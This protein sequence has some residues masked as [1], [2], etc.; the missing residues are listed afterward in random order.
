MYKV[1]YNQKQ[2]KTVH[3]YIKFKDLIRFRYLLTKINKIY[4]FHFFFISNEAT[5]LISTSRRAKIL[6]VCLINY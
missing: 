6:F 1:R 2:N 3:K 5:E 4:N